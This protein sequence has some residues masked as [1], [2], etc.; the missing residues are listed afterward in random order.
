LKGNRYP[1]SLL[2]YI[3]EEEK[4]RLC[5]WGAARLLMPIEFFHEHVQQFGIGIQSAENIGQHF[6]TSRLATLWHMVNCYPRKCGLIIWKR[7]HKPTQQ[8]SIPAS[9]QIDI[10]GDKPSSHG[11]QKE[12][13]VQ[14]TV[15]GREARRYHVPKHKSVESDSLIARA[16][17]D[18]ELKTGR[19]HVDLV[20]LE[21]EVE[22]EA[23]PFTV[24]DEPHVLS[25]FHWP[26]RLF[27]DRN[28][29]ENMFTR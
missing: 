18:D 14:W 12:V 17:D 10:W 29:Q 6:G 23:V 28:A 1:S 19:E 24:R 5:N 9:N 4:E 25:L 7:A 16:L 3:E 27:A 11:P 13:R 2:P 26:E 8:N 15:F 20:G 21:G 22:I